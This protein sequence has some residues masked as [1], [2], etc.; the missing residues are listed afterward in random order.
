MIIEVNPLPK[1]K[2]N[3]INKLTLDKNIIKKKIGDTKN[4]FNNRNLPL[5]MNLKYFGQKLNYNINS[6][7]YIDLIDFKGI[8]IFENIVTIQTTLKLNL[9][10][11]LF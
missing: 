3:N 4:N 11:K 5:T 9:V 10:L 8:N 2:I 1:L 6:K 7:G